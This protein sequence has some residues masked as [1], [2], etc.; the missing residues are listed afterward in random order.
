M[1]KFAPLLL[2]LPALVACGT[3]GDAADPTPVTA[4]ETVTV[5]VTTTE[6]PTTVPVSTTAPA[7]SCGAEA[8]RGDFTEPVVMYCDGKWA[9]AGQAFTDHLIVYRAVDGNWAHYEAHGRSG[10]T[11]YPCFDEATITADGV[12]A[13]LLGT[14][15]LC[16]G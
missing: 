11:G 3:D 1:R 15:S 4:T 2:L 8:F 7:P 5:E 6:D 16:Q 12:P 10:I 9:R 14:L 13:E